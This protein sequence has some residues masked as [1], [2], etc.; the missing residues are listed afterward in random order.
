M[1]WERRCDGDESGTAGGAPGGSVVRQQRGC[2]DSDGG[3]HCDTDNDD[4]DPA[5][6]AG[7][8]RGMGGP[9]PLLAGHRMR[10]LG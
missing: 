3:Q 4:Q 5:S 9:G 2:A 6:R 8:A 7:V 1:R 10:W